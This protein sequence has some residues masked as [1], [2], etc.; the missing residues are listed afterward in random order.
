M[1]ASDPLQR[2]P[3]FR[4]SNPEELRHIGTSLFGATGIDLRNLD[5]FEARV[6]LVQLQEIGLAFG[7]TTAD[8][9]IDHCAADFIRLQIALQGHANTSAGGNT[10]D[11]NQH[12]HAITPSGVSSRTVCA[13][14]HQRLTLRLNEEG[15]MRKLTSLLGARP[16]G[17]LAFP[18]AADVS[19]V[20]TQGL[21]RLIDFLLEQLDSEAPLPKAVY[22]ELEQAVQVAF[23]FASRNSFS[24]LLDRSEKMPGSNVVRRLEQ[25]I[26][27][28]W[29]E[30]ITIDRLATEAGVSARAVFKNFQHSRGYSPMAFV[31]MVRLKRA[32]EILMS[33][34][35]KASVTAV[36]FKCNFANLGHFAKYYRDTF[37]ELPSETIS[38]TR[39]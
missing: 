27:A 1:G 29:H 26:E 18:A 22:R 37:G 17:E 23:L 10:I 15:L 13:A 8:L 38:R 21:S 19:S 3:V 14:G 31:K 25:F 5:G 32:R 16:P 33:G 35:P 36:A 4:T 24:S 2:F 11:I 28:N 39:Q 12:Q 20:H 34:D 9:T 6:N 30:A 7:A